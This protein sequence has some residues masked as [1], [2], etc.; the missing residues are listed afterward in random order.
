M[1]SIMRRIDCRAEIRTGLYAFMDCER[2][3]NES[4]ECGSDWRH[5]SI[6]EVTVFIFWYPELHTPEIYL[7]LYCF[8]WNWKQFFQTPF[9]KLNYPRRCCCWWW[10]SKFS[11]LCVPR[12]SSRFIIMD[13]LFSV[14]RGIRW[15]FKHYLSTLLSIYPLSVWTKAKEKEEEDGRKN[16][17]S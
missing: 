4:L 1:P 12:E 13:W 17:N 15:V 9:R 5:L 11:S 10:R 7:I 2:R 14:V 6:H 8:T 16:E 3:R